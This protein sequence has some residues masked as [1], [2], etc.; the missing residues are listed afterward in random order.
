MKRS[1]RP[2]ESHTFAGMETAVTAQAEAAALYTA[3]ELTKR[4]LEDRQSIDRATGEME[5]HSP[6][7]HGT[8]SNPTLF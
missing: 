5:R 1:A 2:V 8:G 4:L 6:L 7:F 3:E